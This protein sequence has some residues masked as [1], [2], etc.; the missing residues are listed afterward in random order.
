MMHVL[1]RVAG[2]AAEHVAID[3]EITGLLLRQ[4]IEDMARAERAQ[5]RGRIRPAGMVALTAAAVE[6]DA[7]AAVP[8]HDVA[9]AACDLRD[10]GIPVDGLKAAV[11]A[12]A[13]RAG[14]AVPVMGVEGNP[15]GFVTEVTLR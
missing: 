3:P 13:Q 8:V 10:R 4:R 12:A 1:G 14:Q 9:Q 2:L 5:E 15:R 11:G 7:L 6:R